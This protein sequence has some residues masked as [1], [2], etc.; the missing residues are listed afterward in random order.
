MAHTIRA[1]L[2]AKGHKI[3]V[4]ESLE[5]IAQAFGT[6]DWNTLAALI[7]D[8]SEPRPA[9]AASDDAQTSTGVLR[10]LISLSEPANQTLRRAVDDAT[11]RGHWGQFSSEHV[12][13]AL[14]EDPEG[15]KMMRA[16]GADLDLVKADVSQYLDGL[17]KR[18]LDRVAPADQSWNLG[19]VTDP[20]IAAAAHHG[21]TSATGA[22]ILS[23]IRLEKSSRAAQILKARGL[24][25]ELAWNYMFA[26][27]IEPRLP[28]ALNDAFTWIS[29]MHGNYNYG[30]RER[31]GRQ[32]DQLRSTFRRAV[33]H[34][35]K[36]QHREISPT[37]LLL[38]LVDD[39][40]ASGLMRACG[41]D[42]GLV[43]GDVGKHLASLPKGQADKAGGTVADSWIQGR[44]TEATDIAKAM[45]H[46]RLTGAHLLMSLLSERDSRA[47]Q[48]LRD[49][50]MNRERAW[51]YVQRG[52]RT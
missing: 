24:N 3:S 4:G 31:R 52:G 44:C 51:S 37:H 35:A 32:S 18:T 11:R 46:R 1:A 45:D 14:T 43:R 34:T 30:S 33:E 2:A 5:L 10:P 7:R 20:A 9:A 8:E 49:R 16:C 27:S 22:H 13:L 12:L 17:R 36:R 15:A 48:I 29:L 38:A 42:P 26:Q 23:G 6:A 50:A 47:S 21:Q 28:V 19:F 25:G 39:P 40:D 41:V